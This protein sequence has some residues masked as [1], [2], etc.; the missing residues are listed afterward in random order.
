MR[1]GRYQAPRDERSGCCLEPPRGP[2]IPDCLDRRPD[3]QHRR[4]DGER[5]HGVAD[6]DPGPV[7]ADGVAGE[8]GDRSPAV[9]VRAPGRGARRYRRSP[10]TADLR[11]VLHDGP[12]HRPARDEHDRT[13]HPVDAADPDFPDRNRNRLRDACLSGRAAR[14]RSQEAAATRP[15]LE[16]RRHQH[17][18][19][20]RPGT[21]RS[22]GRR[23]RG[24]GGT[25]DQ[26]RHLW[27][28][29]LRVCAAA[30]HET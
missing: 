11:S 29:H 25:R 2:G 30:A 24:G 3:L 19:H 17:L 6:D 4:L 5:G 23:G 12:R 22:G 21:R 20:R 9:P 16:R 15:C 13:D 8:R 18:P 27:R 7:A 10:Q 14:T 26:R 1:C 28:R